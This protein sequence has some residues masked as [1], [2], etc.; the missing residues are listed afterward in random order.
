MGGGDG[1]GFIEG[2]IMVFVY[3]LIAIG[4]FCSFIFIPIL[5]LLKTQ[6]RNNQR[7]F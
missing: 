4:I 5:K 6:L 7:F 3:M 2:M 1:L